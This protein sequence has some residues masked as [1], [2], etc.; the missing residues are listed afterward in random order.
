LAGN[1]VVVAGD[2]AVGIANNKIY[3][4]FTAG[5]AKNYEYSQRFAI[6]AVQ[7]KLPHPLFPAEW[8]NNSGF[9]EK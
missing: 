7:R 3:A 2:R 5:Q 8:E 4:A 6:F 9:S 1:F